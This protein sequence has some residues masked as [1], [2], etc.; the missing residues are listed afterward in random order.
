MTPSLKE[1]ESQIQH[2][3]QSKEK[4]KKELQQMID[5]L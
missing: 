1:V 2:Y 3:N 4:L 5:S